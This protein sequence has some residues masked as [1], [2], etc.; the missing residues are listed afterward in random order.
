DLIDLSL[1]GKHAH[2]NL[3]GPRFGTLHAE[4]DELVESW[5]RLA[6]E[7]AERAVTLG[8]SPDGRVTTVAR[9]SHL[10]P[11][12]AGPIRDDDVIVGLTRRLAD[13]IERARR[14]M[15]EA[16][17]RDSVSEDLLIGVVGTL[18]KQHWLLRAQLASQEF[19]T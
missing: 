9:S 14:A 15:G 2:W 12:P 18:E 1:Q 6:D 10:D 11:F 3:E 16:A 8:S 17:V 13:I 19:R 5:Q 7:V 4:L